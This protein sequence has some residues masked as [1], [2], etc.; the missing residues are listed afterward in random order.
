MK[1]KR[2]V[3]LKAKA[4]GTNANYAV[5]SGRNLMLTISNPSSLS[6]ASR[7]GMLIS[8]H[9]LLRQTSYK[10]SAK[11]VTKRKRKQK[12]S[13]AAQIKKLQKVYANMMTQVGVQINARKGRK[14]N[15]R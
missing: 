4:V 14:Y 2:G 15:G 9:D 6:A 11:T 13:N 12:I 5:K 8:L 10:G 3:K 1:L 7:L